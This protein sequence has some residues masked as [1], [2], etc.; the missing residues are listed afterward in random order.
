MMACIN[1]V[2]VLAEDMAAD[3]CLWRHGDGDYKPTFSSIVTWEKLRAH[4]PKI[5][6]CK[7]VW[8]QHSIHRYSFIT[9]LA[10]QD[11]L[12]TG[13]R[14]RAWGCIEPCLLCG[15]PDETRDHLLCACPTVRIDLVRF[16]LGSCVNPDWTITVT[17]LIY[18]RRKEILAFLN[19]LSKVAFIVFGAT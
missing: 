18:F 15:E 10:F 3:R 5:S 6:W 4:Y 16:M 8:F 13:A 11:R 7:V 19:L 17:S 12:P 14:S 2:P 9:W 1:S